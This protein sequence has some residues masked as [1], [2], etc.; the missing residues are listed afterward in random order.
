MS[1]NH[2]SSNGADDGATPLAKLMFGWTSAKWAPGLMFILIGGLSLGVLLADFVIDRHAYEPVKF[3]L[4]PM[5]YGI[6]G[7]AAFFFVVL[8]GWPLGRMLRRDENFYGDLEGQEA[9]EPSI[10]SDE[11]EGA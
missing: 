4:M 6:Y 7:F 5:F 8:C 9:A 1:E 3:T 11:K 10:S 2:T